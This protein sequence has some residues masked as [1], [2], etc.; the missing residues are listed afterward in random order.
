VS[1]IGVAFDAILIDGYLRESLAP[2]G[3][4]GTHEGDLA[5]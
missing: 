1:E 4:L 3:N 5:A 2:K